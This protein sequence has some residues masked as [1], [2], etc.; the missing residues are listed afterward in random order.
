MR[1]HSQSLSH[2][3]N[4]ICAD[5]RVLCVGEMRTKPGQKAGAAQSIIESALINAAMLD[6]FELLNIKGTKTPV[7]HITSTGNR[8]ARRWLKGN[9]LAVEQRS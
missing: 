2:A 1:V 4:R 7:H 8:E 5:Q 6:G 9:H 3:R